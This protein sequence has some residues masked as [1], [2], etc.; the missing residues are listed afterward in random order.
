MTSSLRPLRL[1]A[2]LAL[3][4]LLALLACSGPQ[5]G[6]E[7][8]SET[9]FL[10]DCA[11]GCGGLD[12]LCGVCTRSCDSDASCATLSKIATCV[13]PANRSVQTCSAME[14][15][16]ICDVPCATHD[17]CT[18]LGVEFSCTSGHCRLPV[19]APCERSDPT[20]AGV[21]LIGDVMLELTPFDVDLTTLARASGAFAADATFRNYAAAAE[22]FLASGS[23]AIQNQYAR[24]KAESPATLV[25]MTGGE[26]DVLQ[27]P[28]GATPTADCAE[29][30]TAVSG[31]EALLA[32][33][34]A[35][36]VRDVVYVFYADPVGRPSVLAGLDVLRP[37]AE[38]ACA[39]APLPC[40]FVDLRPVFEGRYDEYVGSD[41]LVWSEA[42]AQAAASAVW[43]LMQS[44]CLE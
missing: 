4:L 23:L 42:G 8:G 5:G 32:T 36:G 12:C 30:R 11:L 20:G 15:T 6:K 35:D 26:T 21:V 25:I 28:C 34:A 40:H 22:S 7:T 16:P 17:E 44:K 31:F 33:M 19:A 13:A 39:T 9:H 1:A 14:M 29:L 41:G 24:A 10:R 37:L 3:C 38:S 2:L 27:E 43:D 18:E